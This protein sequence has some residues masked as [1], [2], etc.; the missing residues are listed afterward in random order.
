MNNEHYQDF[1]KIHAEIVQEEQASE[2][3]TNNK[4][5]E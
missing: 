1:I 4:E 5:A 3:E 2:K